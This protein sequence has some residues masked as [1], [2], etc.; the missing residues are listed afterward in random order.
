M[1]PSSRT[2]EGWPNRCPACGKEVRIEPSIP[3]G[4]APCPNCGHLL[5]FDPTVVDDASTNP[6]RRL[7]RVFQHAAKQ[8][9][10]G[11]RDYATELLTLCVLA[12]R[13]NV[14]YARSFISN[15]RDKY[16]HNKKGSPLAE[17]KERAARAAVKK[18]FSEHKWD[19]VFKN[20]L[21][22]LRVNPWDVLALGTMAIACKNI[23]DEG[24]ANSSGFS[25]CSLFYQECA[26]DGNP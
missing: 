13:G 22:I 11:N 8:A 23:A 18:A 6:T 24:I 3:P 17:F 9:A 19:D 2:P 20:G 21:A 26:A 16:D 10:R 5:W 25:E 4:D 1:K 15:L 14:A 12:D 7:Q